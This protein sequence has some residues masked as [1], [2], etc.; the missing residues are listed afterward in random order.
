MPI[1]QMRLGKSQ[2]CQVLTI[3]FCFKPLIWGGGG[4]LCY[5]AKESETVEIIYLPRKSSELQPEIQKGPEQN[6][7]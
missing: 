5:V 4:A 3:K 6:I 2:S 1:A 7:Y